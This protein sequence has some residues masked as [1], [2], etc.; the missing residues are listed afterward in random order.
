MRTCVGGSESV[1]G[2]L[3]AVQ[4]VL[5][6]YDFG[7]FPDTE[8]VALLRVKTLRN[9]WKSNRFLTTAGVVP[10]IS[11]LCE[12]MT[13]GQ[14]REAGASCSASM[15]EI[16]GGRVGRAPKEPVSDIVYDRQHMRHVDA[17][18]LPNTSYRRARW[19]ACDGC[20]RVFNLLPLHHY[21]PRYDRVLKG[22]F[23]ETFRPNDL[24]V[25]LR[26]EN[27]FLPGLGSE[28]LIGST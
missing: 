18:E 11:F 6:D 26:L 23:T 10:N 13:V 17:S 9:M 25:A 8:K 24:L 28:G 15:P 7:K 27:T 1:C 14:L 3:L 5:C 21:D 20:V 19:Y 4:K 12:V 16:R 22:H 2:W